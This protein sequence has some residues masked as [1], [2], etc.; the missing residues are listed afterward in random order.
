MHL[1]WKLWE[2]GAM[3]RAWRMDT[4]KRPVAMGCRSVGV[5]AIVKRERERTDATIGDLQL[6]GFE[7]GGFVGVVGTGNR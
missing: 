2:Q 5:C 6:V 7:V 4:A 1:K 3:K